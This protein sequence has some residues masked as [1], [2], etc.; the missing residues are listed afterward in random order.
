[1][2]MKRFKTGSIAFLFLFHSG[3]FGSLCW[4]CAET[5]NKVVAIVNDEVIT[6][7]ELNE[8]I[9]RLTG[10]DPNDLKIQDE[11][12]FLETQRKVLNIMIEDK[13]AGEKIKEMGI[14]VTPREVDRAIENLKRLNTLSDDQFQAWVKRQGL[15]YKEYRERIKSQL[16]KVRIINIEVRS[17]IIIREEQVEEYYEQSKDKF[18][19]EGSVRLAAIVL[20]AQGPPSPQGRSDLL[21]QKAKEILSKIRQGED[22]R[23][24]ARQHSQVPG[25][26]DGGD[27]G[28]F[29][30][31]QLDPDLRKALEKMSPG[32]VSEPIIR[33][34]GVQII[35]L[36]EK[37]KGR[38]KSFSEVK[39][40]ILD[41]LY[42]K[43]IEKRYSSWIKE[44]KERTYTK[45]FL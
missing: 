17:K 33:P 5:T 37:D 31:S 41:L 4:V 26:K 11:K 9:R 25:A 12:R 40:V 23:E 45:T 13:I 35:K 1:M 15:S 36:I 3:L 6:L 34:G 39:L 44:L 16:E 7:H 27:I 22:F 18:R 14:N 10:S 29:K 38:E 20:K 30:T 19:A 32:D 28:V 8:R 21:Y 24:L 42:R 43:E 2:K